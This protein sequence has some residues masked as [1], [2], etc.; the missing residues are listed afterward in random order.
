LAW[1]LSFALR[2]GV[3]IPNRF[4]DVIRVRC[5][6]CESAHHLRADITRDV[7]QATHAA[8]ARK[9][10]YSHWDKLNLSDS[11]DEAPPP[12]AVASP[13]DFIPGGSVSPG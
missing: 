10:D 12:K 1:L 8:M 6:L 11:D 13:S 3:L 7:L 2:F 5:T 4:K 9:I